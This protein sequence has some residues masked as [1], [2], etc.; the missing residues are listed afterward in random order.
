MSL[1]ERI[2]SHKIILALPVVGMALIYMWQPISDYF[3]TGSYDENIVLQIETE[4]N[5]IDDEHQLLVLHVKPVNR[6]SVPVE[7]TS[8]NKKGSLNVEIRKIETTEKNN[9]VLNEHLP[10]VNKIDALRNY[11]NGYLIEPNA[12]YDEVEAISLEKGLYWIKAV[13]TFDNGDF[14]DQSSVVRISNE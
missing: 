1:L 11:K 9:W 6:G 10:V 3:L 14:I 13:L 12:Y 7:I 5:K 4:T 8:N 2:A